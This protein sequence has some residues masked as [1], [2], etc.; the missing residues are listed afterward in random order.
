MR[1]EAKKKNLPW[2]GIKRRNMFS[3]R[4]RREGSSRGPGGSRRSN[5]NG[6]R[7]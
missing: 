5:K 7:D 2:K 6:T 1:K 3:H 4:E